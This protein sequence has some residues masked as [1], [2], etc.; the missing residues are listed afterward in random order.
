MHRCVRVLVVDQA[1]VDCID[2]FEASTTV[3]ISS[4]VFSNRESDVLR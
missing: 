1:S 4:H 2:S 3:E